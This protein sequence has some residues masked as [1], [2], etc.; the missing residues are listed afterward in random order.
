ML[1]FTETWV[2]GVL[3]VA[4]YGFLYWKW[5]R[6]VMH[7]SEAFSV[8]ALFVCAALISWA[9]FMSMASRPI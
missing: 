9:V 3:T 8:R 6:P 1:S 5:A 4:F 7:Q 2:S